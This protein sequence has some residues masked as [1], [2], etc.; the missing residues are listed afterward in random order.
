M[1]TLIKITRIE[2]NTERSASFKKKKT[3]AYCRVST[4]SKAQLAS[5]ESQKL[6]FETLIKSNPAWEY[7]G[8]YYDE[9]ISGTSMD[10]RDGLN[11]LLEDCEA[12]KIELIITK[13]ISR[14]ARNA[15]ECLETIR[16]LQ[17]KNI[18]IIFERENINTGEMQNEFLISV[19]SSFAEDE[20]RSISRNT[21]WSIQ[22]R[23]KDGTYTISS[24]PYGYKNVDK[25][26]VIDEEEAKVVR[27]IFSLMTSGLGCHLIAKKLNELG[28]EPPR[29]E[30]WK[31]GT[32]RGIIKNEK[33]AGD[34]V[35][36]KT[37]TDGSY[38][39]HMNSGEKDQFYCPDH[40]EPIVTHEL[41]EMANQMM[42]FNREAKNIDAS[43]DK[44]SA[45]YAFSGKIVCGE[46]GSHW[47]RNKKNTGSVSWVCKKHLSDT[48]ACSMK[49]IQNESIEHAF[50]TMMNK[51]IAGRRL[52][53]DPF[54]KALKEKK[55][56][57]SLYRLNELDKKLSENRQAKL[58]LLELQSKGFIPMPLFTSELEELTAEKDRLYKEQQE[59]SEAVSGNYT[60]LNE[61][62]ELIKFAVKSPI[63]TAFDEDVF[64][65]YV[66][67]ITVISRSKIAFNLCCGLSLE[68]R[69]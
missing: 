29:G 55:Q 49:S 9:G 7:A 41:F 12:G 17:R 13:S 23:F 18:S 50:V 57:D 59:L 42:D 66:E 60:H 69:V 54:Q 39:R 21:S 32:V 38:K 10:K 22:K 33:Y 30:K 25:E 16:A 37:F 4:D 48:S 28:V 56:T 15:E 65:R 63:L 40:H 51:L 26:M 8:L 45:R 68:E 11:Q 34:A 67:S 58:R 64:N 14:F 19:L 27:Y 36:Q 20:S 5:L 35:F 52:V 62:N 61:V 44:Y 1:E 31:D 43:E 24:P 47:K 46:C 3:A 6:H 2:A 53:L